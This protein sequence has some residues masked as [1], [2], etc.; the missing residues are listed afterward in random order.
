MFRKSGNRFSDKDMRHSKGSLGNRA[1][2]FRH[3]KAW[4]ARGRSST[5]VEEELK[6]ASTAG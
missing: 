3:G 4:L 2:T 6:D 5:I 1:K